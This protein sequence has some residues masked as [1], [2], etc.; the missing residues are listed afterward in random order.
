MQLKVSPKRKPLRVS[1][2]LIL[3]GILTL[4]VVLLL[5]HNKQLATKNDSLNQQT[6]AVSKSDSTSIPEES[7]RPPTTS[8]NWKSTNVNFTINEKH[9]ISFRYPPPMVETSWYHDGRW[10]YSFFESSDELDQY[11]Q[12]KSIQNPKKIDGAY[13]CYLEHV[14]FDLTIIGD[15]SATLSQTS[16]LIKLRNVG[17]IFTTSPELI[18]GMVSSIGYDATISS[19]N[20][21]IGISINFPSPEQAKRL[22]FITETDTFTF[23]K[24]LLSTIEIESDTTFKNTF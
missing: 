5:M 19:S 3:S 17:Q 22:E 20:R 24:D 14:L 8:T 23:F 13:P 4:V 18:S 11:N 1:F 10:T 12:C 9:D 6:E 16:N 7:F 21:V 2:Y 15:G